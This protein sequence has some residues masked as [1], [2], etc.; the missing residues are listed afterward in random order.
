M[1]MGVAGQQMES[2]EQCL[3]RGVPTW[4]E[5]NGAGVGRRWMEGG[6]PPKLTQGM[7]FC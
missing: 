5:V 7:H 6:C 2:S 3:A 1:L 4:E